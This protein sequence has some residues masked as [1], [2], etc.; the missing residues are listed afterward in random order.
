MTKARSRREDRPEIILD[1]AEALLRRSGSRT[2]T[3]D[4]VAAEAGLSK[5]GVLH[6]YASKD[7]LVTALAARKVQR[8]IDGIAAQAQ[9]QPQ[10]PAALP[11]AL[12]AHAREVYAEECGFPDS[13]LIASAENA[14]AVAGFQAFLAERLAQMRGLEARP[15]AGSALV[16]AILGLMLSRSLGFHQLEGADLDRLFHALEAQARALPEA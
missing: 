2:L 8:M 5:G 11:L 9:A 13:L 16:F 15:G 6:H 14:A 7:A 12:I 10:G 1:A 4:A 3:I